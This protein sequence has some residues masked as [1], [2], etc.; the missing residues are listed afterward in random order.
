[1]SQLM[2]ILIGY[3]GSDCSE[4]ALDLLMRAGLPDEAEAL[5]VSVAEMWLPPPPPSAYEFVAQADEEEVPTESKRMYAGGS[6]ALK[7]AEELAERAC[8][9]LQANFPKWQV[10]S[11][12]GFGSPAWELISRAD[13]WKPNLLVVGSHG[14]TALGRMVLGSVSQR[15]VTDAR[16]SVRVARGRVEETDAPI[17]IVLGIDG[18]PGSE[19]AAREVAARPWPPHSEVRLI[20]VEDPLVPPV[21]GL[22]PGIK[23]PV[24]ENKSDRAWV[25][26]ILEAGAAI[27]G[28]SELK[29]TTLIKAGDPKRCLVQAAEEWGA[30]CIFVGSTGFSNRLERFV[31]GS[32]SAAVVAHAHCSVEVIR[33]PR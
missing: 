30:D 22:I 2:K 24:E 5:V 4:T 31:L 12:A 7:K 28:S 20:V 15:V 14:H 33:R 23:Q 32:V 11:D 1:M 26:R 10:T 16:C 19:A 6:A 17:R 8:A 29:V 9:R 18:S 25:K 27:L 21:F 3:D 13:Y